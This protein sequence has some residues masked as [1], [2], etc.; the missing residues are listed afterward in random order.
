MAN[1]RRTRRRRNPACR[2]CDNG[3]KAAGNG[4][5]RRKPK[6]NAAA[7]VAAQAIANA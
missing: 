5:D 7:K 1:H 6:Y 2:I 4:A 3:A